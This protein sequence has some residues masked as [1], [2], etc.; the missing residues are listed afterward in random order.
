MEV[1]IIS[2]YNLLHGQIL[3]AI[4]F[5]TQRHFTLL[6]TYANKHNP[7]A[8]VQACSLK[9]V[10][11]PNCSTVDPKTK[12]KLKKYTARTTVRV[13]AGCH[14][15]RRCFAFGGSNAP[16]MVYGNS[17]QSFTANTLLAG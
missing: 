14:T 17:R 8:A 3:V 16:H 4:V 7:I 13:L 11:T 15:A 1:F 2:T 9:F 10:P 12:M 5:R 6:V